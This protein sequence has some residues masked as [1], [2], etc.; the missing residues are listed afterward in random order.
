[1]RVIGGGDLFVG[2]LND[3]TA[4]EAG[5]RHLHVGLAGGEPE[6]AE[7][8]VVELDGVGGADDES[9]GTAGG[10][11]G[12]VDAPAAERVGC[13]GCGE[14]VEVDGDLF[15]GCGVAPDV[16]GHVA[17]ENHVAGEEFGE[18]DFSDGRETE[19]KCGGEE[20]SCKAKWHWGLRR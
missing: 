14:A 18:G 9:E 3:G 7:E 20:R 10:L 4:G 19:Q 5:E 8:D 15:A 6:V 13:G 1:M 2:V 16:D 11:G 12:E 17:L